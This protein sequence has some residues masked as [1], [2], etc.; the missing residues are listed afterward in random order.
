MKKTILLLVVAVGLVALVVNLVFNPKKSSLN[1]PQTNLTKQ[2]S[3][4]TPSNTLKSYSDPSGFTFNYPDNLSLVNNEVKDNS[5]YA[6]IQLS[7]KDINGSLSLKI[8]DTKFTSA[9][10]WA[11][12]VSS[13]TPKEVNLGNIKAL[14]I[15]TN[16]KVLLGAVDSG[17]F[18]NVEVP[19][20]D[21]KDFWMNVYSKV[22]QDFSFTPSQGE[23]S[24]DV[25][26]EGEEVVQ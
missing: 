11:K 14:E 20:G 7:K 1:T 12:K 25:S 23:G 17:V 2:N 3:E 26:F 24:S 6:D 19:F 13:Q 10:E 15:T 18:F 4:I 22:I 5:T 8:S 21:K 16:D 9:S